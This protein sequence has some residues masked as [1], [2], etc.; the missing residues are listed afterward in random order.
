MK[1]NQIILLLLFVSTILFAN[2]LTRKARDKDIRNNSY[3]LLCES[4]SG[5]TSL[6]SSKN[7]TFYL[8]YENS[9]FSDLDVY[10]EDMRVTKDFVSQKMDV[11]VSSKKIIS[12]CG[13]TVYLVETGY[14][15]GESYYFVKT[16]KGNFYSVSKKLKTIHADGDRL[17]E[18]L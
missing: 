6:V 13:Y 14:I 11:A 17:K 5:N 1:K 2:D 9:L 16:P 12:D 3:V 18:E 8:Y 4:K 10:V 7:G 15:F